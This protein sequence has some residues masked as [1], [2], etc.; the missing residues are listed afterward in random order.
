MPVWARA[1][2][3]MCRTRRFALAGAAALL[4][5]ALCAAAPAAAADWAYVTPP[6]NGELRDVVF[7][8]A[9]HG[10]AVGEYWSVFATADGGKTWTTQ[11]RDPWTGGYQAG[12]RG[13]DFVSATTGW[14]A[15]NDLTVMVTTDG[16]AHWTRQVVYDGSMKPNLEDIAFPDAQHGWVVGSGGTIWAT[17]DGGVSWGFQNVPP[18]AAVNLLAVDFVDSSRGWVVGYYGVIAATVNGGATWTIQLPV[19]AGRPNFAAVKFVDQLNGWAV[20][21]GGGIWATT[22]GGAHWNQQA[23]GTTAQLNAVDFVDRDHGCAVGP[24]DHYLVTSNGGATWTKK[25]TGVTSPYATF[26][27][28]DLLS[29]T[30]AWGCGYG[31]LFKKGYDTTK[32][33]A[34]ALA[35]VTV[36]KGRKAVLRYRVNDAAA[37]CRVTLTVKKAAKIVKVLTIAGA[38]TNRDLTASFTCT[39]AKG[40][41]S[42]QVAAT[43]PSGNVGAAS[44]AKKLTVK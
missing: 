37:T 38:R 3:F 12:F 25:S 14:A 24:I 39:L 1:A 19:A 20:G 36:K 42:W 43:D 10:W 34:K 40:V 21:S 33:V 29:E 6:L 8:D 22:D 9:Q 41:Y 4:A 13:V 2:H 26:L 30:R 15:G 17:S 5:A 28:L 18:E 35:N 31:S 32:P 16:G 7:A 23:S 44:A 11:F 27:G